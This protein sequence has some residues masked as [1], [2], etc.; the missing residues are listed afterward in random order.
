DDAGNV[1]VRQAPLRIANGGIERVEIA[2][3]S[4][5]PAQVKMGGAL[6]LRIKVV[7]SGETT[8]RTMGPPPD[9]AY[10]TS[11]SFSTIRDPTSSQPFQPSSGAW[12]VGLGWQDAPQEL[13][14]RWGLL[15]DPNGTI[16]PGGSAIVEATV[17]LAPSPEL[18]SPD[19]K[20]KAVRFWVGAIREGVGLAS[21]RT[22]DQVVTIQP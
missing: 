17:T 11:E 5:G 7:N 2:D 1:R 22:G 20:P 6:R 9:S 10:R 15:P 3:V 14:L 21:G 12:R 16:P 8:I 18:V 4:I 19:G 13:P